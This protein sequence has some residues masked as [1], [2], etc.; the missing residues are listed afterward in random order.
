MTTVTTFTWLHLTD[1]HAGQPQFGYDMGLVIGRIIADIKVLVDRVG[2]H[3]RPEAILFTGDLAYSGTEYFSTGNLGA[4]VSVEA[5]L[6]G[7]LH[8]WPWP[9]LPKLAPIPGNHDLAWQPFDLDQYILWSAFHDANRIVRDQFFT[10]PTDPNQEAYWLT[11][12]VKNAFTGYVRW[13]E[14][15][16]LPK[17][18]ADRI[19][20]LPGEYATT[21]ETRQGA[22]VG[23]LALNTAYYDVP[24][25][26]KPR[27]RQLALHADQLTALGFADWYQR[28]NIC[29]AMTHHPPG[30]I[31]ELPRERLRQQYFIGDQIALH[32][33]G[34]LHELETARYG[35]GWEDGTLIFQGRSLFGV[36]ESAPG[37]I[38][39]SLGYAIGQ[40]RF[41]PDA[42]HATLRMYPRQA[43]FEAG[44][45]FVFKGDGPVGVDHHL[46][47]KL[48]R[49]R[50]VRSA[51]PATPV[52]APPPKERPALEVLFDDVVDLVWRTLAEPSGQSVFLAGPPRY[53]K[54]TVVQVVRDRLDR[55]TRI[56]YRDFSQLRDA[57][58]GVPHEV[59]S[60]LLKGV[61]PLFGRS[62]KDFE[63]LGA[64]L[65]ACLDD[66]RC[67]LVIDAYHLIAGSARQAIANEL[68][69]C[70]EAYRP[71]FRLL[72]LSRRP[73]VE[74][75]PIPRTTL[76]PSSFQTM[77]REV[78]LQSLSADEVDAWAAAQDRFRDRAALVAWLQ[79][80]T[81]GHPWL[82]STLLQ[83]LCDL[84]DS[85]WPAWTRN[86]APDQERAQ[87]LHAPTGPVSAA[88]QQLRNGLTA[89]A[90]TLEAA[91]N[92]SL[93]L[94]L[95]N[96][97]V[98][99]FVATC[100]RATR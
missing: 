74:V 14:Q 50:P 47:D 26:R 88:V 84:A 43:S 4:D 39:P 18:T 97:R 87:G 78:E 70:M 71:R 92:P 94:V 34:H 45:Q 3:L 66:A 33:C 32:L 98:I 77:L 41:S 57:T 63:D 6:T 62:P 9:S 99:P 52:T 29:L 5:L 100:F 36:E 81:G 40:L 75:A 76:E 31:H 54:T 19:G 65:G 61:A 46:P 53:G 64:C 58:R 59:T 35:S 8:Q 25:L 10:I 11:H 15:T 37:N 13:L 7:L 49:V 16:A 60:F 67:V 27:P 69:H 30:W 24:V 51:A 89:F 12:K 1:M 20:R 48:V 56:A 42:E 82:L 23:L 21:F 73:L 90:P 44:G 91:R 22:R 86:G 38:E 68:R 55:K 72:I 96:G 83:A 28:N 85:E 95:M 2:E 79:R 80:H 17:V 93:G